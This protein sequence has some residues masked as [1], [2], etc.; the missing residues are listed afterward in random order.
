MDKLV[1]QIRQM[2]SQNKIEDAYAL[3]DHIK[4]PYWRSYALKWVAEAMV[5][6][7]SE[8]ALNIAKKIEI[9]TLKNDT[10]LF[11]SYE[12]AKLRKFKEAIRA[13]KLINNN[14]LKKKAFRGISNC[15]AKAII[16]SNA[17]EV[18]LSDFDLEERNIEYLMPLPGGVYYKDGK[19]LVG[20]E[21]HRIKG[22][23]KFGVL[24]SETN[25]F[26]RK[27]SKLKF[28]IKNDEKRELPYVYNYI[29]RL[30]S[31]KDLQEAERLALGLEESYASYFLE[32][33]GIEYLRQGKI[34]NAQ[35][36]LEKLEFADYLTNEFVKFYLKSGDIEMAKKYA[37]KLFNPVFK[38]SV[39]YSILLLEGINEDFLRDLFSN[40]SSYKLGRILKFL[41]F[42][43]LKEAKEKKS[44]S[45]LN[46]SKTLFLLGKREHQ[47]MY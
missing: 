47:K 43:L 45:L 26:F 31:K 17:G 2:L 46:L 7:H 32:E 1:L 39:A 8:K 6:L 4:D 16:E 27:R 12:F 28:E 11:L 21:I 3:V 42:E 24:I 34:E 41:A 19:F 14:Y 38:L 25:V 13:A 37:L 40:A 44:N 20:S 22:E 35:K 36:I 29:E 10:L 18:R 9:E 5:T 23:T 30:I 33:I 15:L